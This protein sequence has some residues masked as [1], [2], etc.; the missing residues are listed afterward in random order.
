MVGSTRML[1][2]YDDRYSNEYIV[3]AIIEE[4]SDP[5]CYNNGVSLDKF[6]SYNGFDK[7]DNEGG[8]WW[9]DFE[10]M[11]FDNKDDYYQ[12]AWDAG[13]LSKPGYTEV[14]DD[15]N[16]YFQGLFL[17]TGDFWG[18]FYFSETIRLKTVALVNDLSRVN[19][20][21]TLDYFN[22]LTNPYTGFDASDLV[23]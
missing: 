17:G 6:R 10:A 20:L 16:D 8:T 13:L 2:S 9:D 5:I 22:D 7:Y 15:M 21:W 14:Y 3:K 11:T 19:P 1:I 18:I 4:L 23:D 12:T